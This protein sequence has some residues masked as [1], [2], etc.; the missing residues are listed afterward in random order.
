MNVINM[1]PIMTDSDNNKALAHGDEG[2][3]RINANELLQGNK[4]MVIEH[5]ESQYVLRLT[6]SNKLILTK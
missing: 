1:N 5:G 2:I 4:T 6:R 3:H